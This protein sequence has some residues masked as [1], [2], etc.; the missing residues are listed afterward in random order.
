MAQT[1]FYNLN[2]HRKYPFVFPS[3]G[4][5]NFGPPVSIVLPDHCILDC[6]FILGSSANFH[7]DS[8]WVQLKSLTRIADN[9]I[10]KFS[11]SST[12]QEFSFVRDK[13]V[14][15]GATDFVETGDSIGF[16]VTGNLLDLWSAL[17]SGLELIAW[18]PD[19]Q[20]IVEPALV[21]SQ[22]GHVVKTLNVG[23]L[24]KLSGARCCDPAPVFNNDEV[25]MVAEGLTG[26]VVFKSGYNMIIYANLA[27]PTVTFS[28]VVGQG[29]GE[30]CNLPGAIGLPKCA[31]MIFTINGVAP[32]ENGVFRLSANN[33]LYVDLYPSLHKI[34]IRGEL[35][36]QI[37]CPE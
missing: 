3:N 26:Q 22:R 27:G 23:N 16:L 19:P 33:G 13:N 15:W 12:P 2:E 34:I 1:E 11:V 17:P 24:K 31:D 10:F 4:V 7:S 32:T 20:P 9:I 35:E 18:P 21:V 37:Q 29:M 25:D 36:K 5:F 8:D 30:P 6:G 28:A 14:A